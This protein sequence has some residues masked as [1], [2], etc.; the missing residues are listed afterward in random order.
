[1]KKIVFLLIFLGALLCF[2]QQAEPL[3]I[4]FV[5]RM[6]ETM[7]PATMDQKAF[8]KNVSDSSSFI[9]N[10]PQKNKL[11]LKTVFRAVYTDRY[12]FVM[13]E[14][15]EPRIDQLD[16]QKMSLTRDSGAV[17]A[18]AHVEFFLDPD[19]HGKFIGQVVGNINGGIY[20]AIVCGG[21]KDWFYNVEVKAV[22]RKKAWRLF[23]AFPFKDKGVDVANVFGMFPHSNP[24]IGF[25][26]CRSSSV[27]GQKATQWSKTPENS[28]DR[29]N[30]FGV[31][32]MSDEKNASDALQ[33]FLARKK[34]N[35][36]VL[37]GSVRNA[38]NIYRMAIEKALSAGN[39]NG[40]MLPEPRRSQVLSEF[41]NLRKVLSEKKSDVELAEIL[42]RCGALNKE[43]AEKQQ[44]LST[45]I[46]DEI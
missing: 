14:A 36:I 2:G 24:V 20:D 16:F 22:K 34:N 12:L 31:L 17:F 4:Y 1:M 3:R 46:L 5:P 7:T 18:T 35:G 41:K 30:Q 6:P 13:V 27:C 44:M 9:L 40:R 10:V 19:L 37:E 33:S 43:I 28:Y 45:N 21:S 29:P 38:G 25:N 11:Y 8:W 26:V 42:S 32:V 39:V 15:E 23:V